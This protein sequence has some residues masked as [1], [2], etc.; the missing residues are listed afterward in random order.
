MGCSGPRSCRWGVVV[1]A[2]WRHDGHR[3]ARRGVDKAF[4]GILA[5]YE[6]QWLLVMRWEMHGLAELDRR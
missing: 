1:K 3:H 4:G 5:I 2:R 6:A